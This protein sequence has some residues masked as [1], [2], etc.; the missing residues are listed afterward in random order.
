[1]NFSFV[2]RKADSENFAKNAQLSEMAPRSRKA[3]AG[4]ASTKELEQGA[5]RKQRREDFARNAQPSDIAL[6]GRKAFSCLAPW[7]LCDFALDSS[8]MPRP[9]ST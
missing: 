1:V 8:F 9:I 3:P 7:R 5:N 6:Q 4:Q 2:I